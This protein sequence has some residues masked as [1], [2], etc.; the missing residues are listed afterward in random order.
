MRV[1]S[2]YEGLDGWQEGSCQY[3]T[4]WMGGKLD[5]VS[6]EGFGWMAK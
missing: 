1:V 6:T 3:M 5:H 2:V 4:V